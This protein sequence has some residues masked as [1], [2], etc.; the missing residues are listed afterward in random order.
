MGHIDTDSS[1]DNENTINADQPGHS[2]RNKCVSCFRK[3]RYYN[4][5]GCIV[6]LIYAILVIYAAVS[7]HKGKY[8]DAAMKPLDLTK[9]FTFQIRDW[10]VTPITDITV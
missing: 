10:A 8:A 5:F 3:Q 6:S 1:D 7:F 2:R 4:I 9:E